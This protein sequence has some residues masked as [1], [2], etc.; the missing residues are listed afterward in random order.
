[1]DPC[2]GLHPRVFVLFLAEEIAVDRMLDDGHKVELWAGELGMLLI[3]AKLARK[4][5]ELIDL[6]PVFVP[7]AA[8]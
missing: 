1:M 5:L 7:L 8:V 6:V 2:E 4:Y 3:G